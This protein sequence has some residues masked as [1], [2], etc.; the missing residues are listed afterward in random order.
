MA[1]WHHWWNGHELGHTLGKGEGQGGLV[2]CSH[3]ESD[4]TERLSLSHLL[5]KRAVSDLKSIHLIFPGEGNGHP[6]QYS[7]LE[8]SM[9][10]GA[11]QATVHGVAKSRTRLSH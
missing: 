7:C 10:R 2:C 1:G 3:K 9:D 6:L 4:R 8:N 5:Q 11:W